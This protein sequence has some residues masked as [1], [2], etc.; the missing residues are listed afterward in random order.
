MTY[1]LGIDLGTTYTAAATVRDGR[2]EIVNLGNRTA[3]IPSVVLL[4]EDETILAG[5]AAERRAV[6]EPDRFA[7][8]FKR[9]FGDTTPILLGGVPYSADAL[10]A[11][12]L[13][14]VYG[15]VIELEGGHPES[16]AVSHPANWGQ[17]KLDLLAQAVRRADLD[18][19]F[20]SEPEAAALAYASQERVD[21]GAVVAV[22]DLGGGTFD[23]AVLRR[24]DTSFEILGDP[25]GIERLGGIDFDEAVFAHVAQM[26]DGALGELAYDDPQA[27]A[28]VSRLRADCVAAKEAL[29]ADTDVLIPV[30]LPTVQTDVR[31]TRAELERLIRPSLSD[32]LEATRRALRS[33]G[34]EPEDVAAVLLVGGSS[35]IPL[36]AQLVGGEFGR[37]VAVDAHP[38]HTV[39]LGAARHAAADQIPQEAPAVPALVAASIAEPVLTPA[40]PP[41]AAVRAP[42]P[43]EPAA[44]VR[45]PEPIEPAAAVRAP[46]PTEQAAP[47]RTPTATEPTAAVL[48]PAPTEPTAAVPAA[49]PAEPAAAVRVDVAGPD[50]E[51]TPRVPA[52]VPPAPPAPGGDWKRSKVLWAVG[53]LLAAVAGVFLVAAIMGPNPAEEPTPAEEAAPTEGAAASAAPEI[54]LPPLEIGEALEAQGA[55]EQ[56]VAPDETPVG[57]TTEPDDG[58]PRTVIASLSVSG[59]SYVIDWTANFEPDIGADHAHFFWDVVGIENAGAP[60]AGPWELTDQQPYVSAGVIRPSQR[61]AGAEQICVTA[62]NNSHTVIDLA[63]FDCRDVPD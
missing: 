41:A 19:V 39:A 25:E 54:Q 32:S 6:A 63:L 2:S 8:E 26:L 45:A 18:A 24:S 34:V 43:I 47:V 29:S 28:A 48:A 14:W 9:R 30:L 40:A 7:R 42:A 62:A 59:D 27:V 60:G 35:R 17:Y 52:D 36:V 53:A 22:Y 12:L 38:K 1:H 61:P 37:P 33:A 15:R 23:A 57:E 49:A 58:A 51:A 20:V 10:S 21:V 55:D 4:R 44:P 46:A 13:R 16:I 11:K 5:E 3:T 50:P 31:L 56:L